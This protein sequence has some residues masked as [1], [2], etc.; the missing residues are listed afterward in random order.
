MNHVLVGAA[1]PLVICAILYARRGGRASGTLLV[2]GPLA[3]LASGI[4]AVAPDLPRA[5]GDPERYLA[6]HKQSW[7][8]WAWGH[9]VI[10]R[11]NRIENWWGWSIAGV[12]LGALILGVAWRE[13]RRSEAEATW[14]T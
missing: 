3:M 10:D 8:T 7:C 6:W 4:V 12:L 9:C 2:L 14:R 5:W 1:L 13:L 11:H